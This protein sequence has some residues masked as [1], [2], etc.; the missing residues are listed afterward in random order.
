VDQRKER[1]KRRGSVQKDKTV[2]NET[3]TLTEV[4]N[5]PKTM[6]E[7]V[8]EPEPLTEAV[9][10]K[11]IVT[12]NIATKDNDNEADVSVEVMDNETQTFSE[13]EERIQKRPLDAVIDELKTV[14]DQSEE[15]LNK[16]LKGKRKKKLTVLV[17]EDEDL[18]LESEPQCSELLATPSRPLVF[19]ETTSPSLM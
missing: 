5:E 8:K 2:L 19:N 9:I 18:L 13:E 14:H 12:D 17:L 10:Q 4:T 16:K 1:R 11:S 15:S 7:V 3:V 6:M